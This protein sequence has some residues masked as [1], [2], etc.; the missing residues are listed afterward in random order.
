M[1]DF[2]PKKETIS[3]QK[4][5]DAQKNCLI[6]L[7][8]EADN[9]ALIGIR[10]RSNDTHIWD[11]IVISNARIIYCAGKSGGLEY[12]T[13]KVGKRINNSDIVINQYFNEAFDEICKYLHL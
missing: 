5:I 2:D 4:F 6:E 9:I 8:Y 3:G 10:A 12:D 11:F 7:I 1:C 13:W